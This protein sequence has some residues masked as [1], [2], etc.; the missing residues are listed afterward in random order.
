MGRLTLLATGA[1]LATGAALAVVMGLS[2]G[3]HVPTRAAQPSVET[4]VTPRTQVFGDPVEAKLILHLDG[5]TAPGQV[6][7]RANFAPFQ[8][9]ERLREQDGKSLRFIYRLE[10]LTKTCAP[11][12]PERTY[13]F[14]PATVALKGTRMRV[15]WPS[16]TVASRLTVEDLVHPRFRADIENAPS[17]SFSPG[18]R[19]LGWSLAGA[20]GLLAV[21]AMALL[22]GGRKPRLATEPAAPPAPARS[23]V[24][25]AL[26]HVERAL[27]GEGSS[28]RQALE[29]L[30]ATL[31]EDEPELADRARRLAWSAGEPRGLPVYELLHAV[32][33][34]G[35]VRTAA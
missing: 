5:S 6:S 20:G 4:R 11:L 8:V 31:E 30:A 15:Q 18:P 12:A 32:R 24:D 33:T 27:R 28:R 34:R 3:R 14:A 35:R 16:L 26:D 19:I 25:E 1:V 2:G 29:A 13:S 10:C 17:P 22:L 23:A 21:A 9:T 7:V